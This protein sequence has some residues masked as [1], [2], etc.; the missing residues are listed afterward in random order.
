MNAISQGYSEFAARIARIQ[1][2][3]AA[4]TQLSFVG[5]DEVYQVPL[6]VRRVKQSSAARL[7]LKI[8]VLFEAAYAATMGAFS[9]AAGKIGGFIVLGLPDPQANPDHEM[10][11]QF[12]ISFVIATVLG[13][14]CGMRWRSHLL[15]KTVGL[16]CGVLLFHNLVHQFPSAFEAMT[17][18][19]WVDQLIAHTQPYSLLW[20]GISIP[21]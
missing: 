2:G 15:W 5:T 14:A 11:V 1:S 6:E 20:R 13:S 9:V 12:V 8:G 17:S 7:F 16:T 4:S 3:A 21:L 19:P 10:M 18:K